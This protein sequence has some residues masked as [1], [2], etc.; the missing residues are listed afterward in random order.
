MLASLPRTGNIEQHS[1]SE[2]CILLSENENAVA[3]RR[4][5]VVPLHSEFLGGPVKKW[6]SRALLLFELL[7]YV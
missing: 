1:I 7:V 2:R 3:S 4:S 5:L 6:G